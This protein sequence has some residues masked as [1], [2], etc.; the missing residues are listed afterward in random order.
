MIVF[1]FSFFPPSPLLLLQHPPSGTKEPFCKAS[2]GRFAADMAI[3]ALTRPVN[4]EVEAAAQ[5]Q[6]PLRKD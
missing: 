1:V 3:F 4:H 6:D 5:P 2:G